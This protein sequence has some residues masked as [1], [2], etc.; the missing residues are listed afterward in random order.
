MRNTFLLI[1]MLALS[2]SVY[3]ADTLFV[4]APEIPVLTNQQDNALFEIR[5]NADKGDV[6]NQLDISLDAEDLSEVE[7]VRLF[8]VERK[9]FP[10]EACISVL[11]ITRVILHLLCC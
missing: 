6:L 4:R 5:V 10:G 3:A 7:A 1:G 9:E 2:S 8:I 11:L